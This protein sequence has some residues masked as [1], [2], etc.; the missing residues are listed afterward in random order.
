MLG[1]AGLFL[2]PMLPIEHNI[3]L[4]IVQSGSMEPTIMTGSLIVVQPQDEYSV[5]DVIMFGSR[6]AKVPTTHRIVDTYEDRG[7]TWFI[8]KGD[9]NE[10]ADAEAVSLSEVKGVV[11]ADVPRLGFVLD[12]TRQPIGFMFLIVLPAALIILSELEKIWRELRKKRKGKEVDDLDDRTDGGTMPDDVVSVKVARHTRMM[13]ISMPVHFPLVPTLDLRSAA[14]HKHSSW[15]LFFKALGLVIVFVSVYASVGL[16]GSTMSYFNDLETSQHNELR[17]IAL[18]FSAAADG[19]TYNFAEGGIVGDDGSM[20]LTIAPEAGSVDMRYGIE[21]QVVGSSSPL[22][23]ALVAESITPFAYNNL[24][25]LLSAHDIS[26]AE[27]WTVTLL[28]PD[29]TGLVGGEECDIDLIF[30][31]WY[32]D[33]IEDQGYYDEEVIPLHFNYLP[34]VALQLVSPALQSFAAFSAESGDG[35]DTVPPEEETPASADDTGE[36]EEESDQKSEPETPVEEDVPEDEK[37]EGSGEET[38]STEGGE[39]EDQ[40]SE[41]EVEEGNDQD[42]QAESPAE[43]ESEEVTEEGEQTEEPEELPEPEA[44]EE[45]EEESEPEQPAPEPAAVDEPAAE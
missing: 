40:N 9:A 12:F 36:S 18:D 28:I 44:E 21:A 8:T 3:E 14:I 45:P 26:F 7:Q 13:D 33:E 27:P 6:Y 10:E 37:A 23:D 22:C 41:E 24:L 34:T 5:G 42:E 29:E 31:A 16:L 17:A 20:I 15:E 19:Q 11:K 2:V 43:E 1:V 4:R 39:S 25:T 35:G 38:G 30:T 32:F